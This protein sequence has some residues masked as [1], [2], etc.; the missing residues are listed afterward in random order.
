MHFEPSRNVLFISE[1]LTFFSL[2]EKKN[3][4]KRELENRR[5]L[6]HYSA[7]LHMNY[8][9][10]RVYMYTDTCKTYTYTYIHPS[11]SNTHAHTRTFVR[12]QCAHNRRFT[13][14][15]VFW[16][17]T[18]LFVSPSQKFSKIHARKRSDVLFLFLLRRSRKS[19]KNNSRKSL[20]RFPEALVKSSLYCG[21]CF[22]VSFSFTEYSIS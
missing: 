16:T 20:P 21:C 5:V 14:S 17:C 9:Y 13:F 12:V 22:I 10:A 7:I 19:L 11:S 3:R 18:F 8:T 1:F 2:K 4:I 15:R 6:R